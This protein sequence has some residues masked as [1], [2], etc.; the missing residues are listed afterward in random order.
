LHHKGCLAPGYD[1]DVVVFDPTEIRDRALYG[2]R[3]CTLPP[4]GIHLV[5]V[6]GMPAVEDGRY[7][8][9]AH[10][11]SV[12]PAPDHSATANADR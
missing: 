9:R 6:R 10:G 3:D 7:T 1:A 5:F 8:G 11:V 2:L 12:R 4:E